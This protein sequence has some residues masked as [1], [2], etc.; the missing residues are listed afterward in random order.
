MKNKVKAPSSMKEL[1]ND[2]SILY[3][4]IRNEEIGSEHAQNASRVAGHLISSV[5]NEIVYKK[6]PLENQD[7]DFMNY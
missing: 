7:I 5:K 6:L 4:Q 2:L 3:A 1:R